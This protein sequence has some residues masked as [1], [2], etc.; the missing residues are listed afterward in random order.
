MST[1][2]PMQIK[3]RDAGRLI[4]RFP[5]FSERVSKIKTL[6]GRR[7]HQQEKYWTVPKI[8]EAVT[9]LL[10]HFA[11]E[12]TEVDPSL[13]AVPAPQHEKPFPKSR[14]AMF[15]R[16]CAALRA[17]HYARRTEQAYGQWVT[18]FNHF[19]HGRHP[20]E[21]AEPEINTFLTHRGRRKGDR[22]QATFQGA[23]TTIS[24]IEK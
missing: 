6:A 8:N 22:G 3:P 2:D 20:A 10:T 7:W 9:H 5:Y 23:Q 14:S 17:R 16:P 19:H 15:A 1:M 4:M 12:P 24:G 18:R 21:M 11:E 13:D